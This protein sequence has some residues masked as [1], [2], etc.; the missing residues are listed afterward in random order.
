MDKNIVL[1]GFMGTGKSSVGGILAG[2]FGMALFE[3]DDEIERRESYSINDIFEKKG[4]AYFRKCERRLVKELSDREGLVISTGGGV[5]LD[6]RNIS[7]LGRN[8]V[9]ICLDALPRSILE[10]T[11]DGGYR[12][13]LLTPDPSKKIEELLSFRKPFY[14]LI[15]H[16]VRTDELSVDEVVGRVLGILERSG[17]RR[18]VRDSGDVDG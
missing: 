8:G 4:E 11:G 7:D 18:D 15:P 5:V 16:H 13:L 12:P 6:G 2:K 10:R 9:L 1:F 3:M 17:W 14:D